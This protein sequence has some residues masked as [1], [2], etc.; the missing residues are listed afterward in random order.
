MLQANSR[1]NY[2]FRFTNKLSNFIGFDVSNPPQKETI[3]LLTKYICC[4]IK[5]F[6]NTSGMPVMLHNELTQGVIL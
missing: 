6:C 3:G 1:V 2:D 5:G 4:D